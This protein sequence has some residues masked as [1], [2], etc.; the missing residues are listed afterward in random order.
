MEE[1]NRTENERSSRTRTYSTDGA[2][3]DPE[4]Q[5]EH[6]ARRTSKNSREQQ[7][8]QVN[9]VSQ[10]YMTNKP[11][12]LPPL[13][14]A[15][16][17]THNIA[18]E[19]ENSATSRSRLIPPKRKRYLNSDEMKRVTDASQNRHKDTVAK[20]AAAAAAAI[21]LD[22]EGAVGRANGRMKSHNEDWDEALR[23]I[24]T[25]GQS[26]HHANG[27]G[28][29][30]DDSNGA[31]SK[32]RVKRRGDQKQNKARGKRSGTQEQ[33]R[34]N[35]ITGDDRYLDHLLDI[36]NFECEKERTDEIRGEES[37]ISALPTG[38]AQIFSSI[39]PSEK[40]IARS[41]SRRL[42]S[43]VI[44]ILISTGFIWLLRNVH[45][46]WRLNKYST[47]LQQL[48]RDEA[49]IPNEAVTRSHSNRSGNKKQKKK[50]KKRG[51]RSL[52]HS[53]NIDSSSNLQVSKEVEW[54]RSEEASDSDSDDSFDQVY[55]VHSGH[56]RHANTIDSNSDQASKGTI[57]TAS[58]TT[59]ES[60]PSSFAKSPKFD[61]RSQASK[62]P[63]PPK[64][65]RSKQDTSNSYGSRRA[66][67]VPTDTQREEAYQKLLA[68]QQ[69]K[70][71]NLI[72]RNQR[73]KSGTSVVANRGLTMKEMVLK[74]I[75][76]ETNPL[77]GLAK[78]TSASKAPGLF[79]EAEAD[80]V[81]RTSPPS[82]SSGMDLF[83]VDGDNNVDMIVSSILDDDGADVVCRQSKNNANLLGEAVALGDLLVQSSMKT[84][85]T[86]P[87]RPILNPWNNSVQKVNRRSTNLDA[88]MNQDGNIGV[89]ANTQL[90]VSAPEFLPSWGRVKSDSSTPKIW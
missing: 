88:S 69:V 35:H 82:L 39:Q 84:D 36:C 23:W 12:R 22:S 53:R 26:H 2:A 67:P 28:E 58:N 27:S 56:R 73:S 9:E 29:D 80:S 17:G 31:S 72:Q 42:R 40:S 66:Y 41:F 10:D 37:F 8:H 43:N 5:E 74:N 34:N 81:R 46:W 24:A 86:S 68:F 78:N 75:P 49:S 38:F 77:E 21:W 85:V 11:R 1:D 50:R 20:V 47:S 70:L 65:N 15:L 79:L 89:D 13:I 63:S 83:E 16:V 64:F 59:F 90:Q 48:L 60:Q 55:L 61:E 14:Q 51:D 76:N 71:R 30:N 4:E 52:G 54:D 3:A 19:E 45:D 33:G 6:S 25:W 18:V 57:S 44:G 7:K 87:N 32:G 62:M